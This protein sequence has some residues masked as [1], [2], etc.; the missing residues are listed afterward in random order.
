MRAALRSILSAE[1]DL[2]VWFPAS[3]D[4][5]LGVKLIVGPDGDRGEESIDVTVCSPAWVARRTRDGG[6]LEGVGYFIV[7]TFDFAQLEACFQRRVTA[8]QGVDWD[9]VAGQLRRL[10]W[11]EFER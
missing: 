1:I 7:D 4:W 2:A 6:I 5:A 8:C 11:W 9:E 10:G 3:T